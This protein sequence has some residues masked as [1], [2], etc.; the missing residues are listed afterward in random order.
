MPPQSSREKPGISTTRTSSPYFSPKSI[1]APRLRASSIG[2]T[3]VRTGRFSK[4]FSLTICSTRPRSSARQ[5]LTV[6][7][8]EAQ[9]VGLDR[10]ARLLDVVSEHVTKSLVEQV[11][12]GVVRHR[13]KANLPG[14]DGA[15]TVALGEALAAEE[16]HLVVADPVGLLELGARA[17]LVVLDE[18]GV[19]DL[20]AAL[21]VEG[22]L[23]ELGEKIAAL[24]L[25]ER[26]D[27]RE[28]LGLLVAD[29]LGLEACIRCELSRPSFLP[30]PAGP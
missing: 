20:A 10:R 22:R 17:R 2:V 23:P 26:A 5:R 12:R 16:Q 1:I 24:E 21:R 6:R 8:V 30:A 3:N 4:T 18:T 19:A 29:E 11:G 9:L 25:L 14:D 7:E 28:H 15:D 13:R 27:L